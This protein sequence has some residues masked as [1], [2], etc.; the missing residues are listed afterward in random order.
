MKLTENQLEFLDV[1]SNY[2]SDLTPQEGDD[3]Y[4]DFN[5]DQTVPKY[6]WLEE[7][8]LSIYDMTYY[9]EYGLARRW[10]G[11]SLLI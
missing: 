7:E 9:K 10:R 4:F 11:E 8:N 6:L 2:I 3:W 1:D 5:L